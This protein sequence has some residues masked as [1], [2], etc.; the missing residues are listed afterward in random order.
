MHDDP[1]MYVLDDTTAF[2]AWF[3]TFKK[4]GTQILM[5]MQVCPQLEFVALLYFGR[6][7]P[8]WAEFHPKR[9]AMPRFLVDLNQ[10]P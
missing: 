8:Y 7:N 3:P 6:T 9:C 4:R 2:K 10:K 5:F 1:G